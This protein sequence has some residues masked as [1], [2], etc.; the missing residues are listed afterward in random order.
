MSP[1]LKVEKLSIG[2]TKNKAV[3][4][5]ISFEVNEGEI[6]GIV[7]ESGSGKSVSSLAVPGLN[8]K[9]ERIFEGKICFNGRELIREN[10]KR[11]PEGEM[12]KIRG[13]EIAVV[14][15]EPMTSLN[16]VLTI[17][18]QMEETLLL[19][20]DMDK[21]ARQ[22]A[23]V[24]MLKEAGLENTAELVEKYPHQLSGGM[25]QRVMI[26]MAML[27]KPK[28]LIADEPTT[29]LD[30][31]LQDKILK[32]LK[33]FN[34]EYKTAII[35]IS[36]DLGVVRSICDNVIVMQNG[37]IVEKGSIDEVFENPKMDYTKTLLKAAMGGVP[38]YSVDPYCYAEHKSVL[39]NADNLD[40]FYRTENSAGFFKGNSKDL[41]KQVVKNASFKLY[42]GEILGIVGES[43]S[44][45]SSLLKVLCGLNGL[46]EGKLE[47]YEK[48]FVPQMVFQDPYSSL[49]PSKKIGW[50]LEEA[51]RLKKGKPED[52]TA[53]NT[54]DKPSAGLEVSN[55]NISE[56][57]S[58]LKV[59]GGNVPDEVAGLEVSDGNISG[60]VSGL[61]VSG[62]DVPEKIAGSGI[63]TGNITD[64]NSS[65]KKLSLFGKIRKK[66]Y[67]Q[68]VYDML[69]HIGLGDKETVQAYADRFPKEFSGGQRQRIAIAM[70]LMQNR[71]IILLDEPVSALDVTIQ[72]QILNLIL[73]LREKFNLSYIFVSH[74]MNVIKR[75]CDRVCVMYKGEIV[76]DNVTEEIFTNP[77]HE[78]TKK[79]I[80]MSCVK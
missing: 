7:G 50:L 22:E 80:S 33:K 62:D 77:K 52:K 72:E 49:N 4:R 46:Y 20:T 21:K 78:Y 51:L 63:F 28:L 12:R 3:T 18:K 6:L 2:F 39:L 67:S 41:K 27:L 66:G 32:L 26:A 61:E 13:N 34:K 58:G 5:D 45:K 64:K 19:H 54:E 69:M 53:D 74:D 15:Q 44:G 23:V 48:G 71:R 17:G 42:D 38:K 43:G 16:P 76:E 30:V 47:Y 14:F 60:K 56:K 55:G 73:E 31:S 9:Q 10:N 37:G 25:R 40:I 11:I 79:L 75:I 36:H 8:S 65:S 29:A 68:E 35:L 57:V 24:S 1:L 70:S 59:S